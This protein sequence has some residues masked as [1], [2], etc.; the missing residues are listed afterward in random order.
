METTSR[1]IGSD[2]CGFN[3]NS[4]EELCLR[5]Q[6]MGAFH[7]FMRYQKSKRW[8]CIKKST[9]KNH[10]NGLIR[11]L[12]CPTFEGESAKARAYEPSFIFPLER[13]QENQAFISGVTSG[14]LTINQ[15]VESSALTQWTPT[16][17]HSGAKPYS[18]QEKNH[19]AIGLPPQDPSMWK[20]VTDATIKANLF[21]Y[22]Y[23]PYLYSLH[24]EASM[25]GKTVIRP[26][27]YEY[28][29]DTRTH[30]LGDEF[31]WG[32]SML[33]APVLKEGATSVLA[34]LPVD[35][36]YSVFDHKYGQLIPHGEQTFPA[37][38]ESLIPV[39]VRDNTRWNNNSMPKTQHHNG[40]HKE[41]CFQISDCSKSRHG[42]AYNI[43][44]FSFLDKADGFLYWDDGDSIVDSFSTYS[45]YHWTFHY[46]QHESRASL[47]IKRTNKANNLQIPTLDTLEIFNYKNFADFDDFT[48]NGEKV[49]ID[50]EASNYKSDEKILYITKK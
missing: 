8:R 4:A 35:D 50:K 18:K 25:Y 21:R 12:V 15:L 2:I 29:T 7:T 13:S 5:W 20:T 28:P 30:D 48:L 14:Y 32:S 10:F 33:I 11:C 9:H 1:Y 47:T 43:R 45:Y 19:N 16:Q 46:N 49:E 26:V 23:L 42:Y 41:K 37:P 39:F 44:L 34:Y 31:L 38:W 40:V 27:F 17:H 24:F 36:W 22:E 6:Q 3:G